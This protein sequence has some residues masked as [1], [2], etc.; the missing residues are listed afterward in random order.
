MQDCNA[1]HILWGATTP[2]TEKEVPMGEKKRGHFCEQE[3]GAVP[4]GGS[5]TM[6]SA[7]LLRLKEA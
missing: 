3:G 5:G 7:R 1:V 6:E 4:K 2:R